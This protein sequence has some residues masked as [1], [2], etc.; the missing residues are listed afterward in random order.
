MFDGDIMSCLTVRSC[1][2]LQLDDVLFDGGIRM[3]IHGLTDLDRILI[4]RKLS[5]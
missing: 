2:V 4:Y 5:P 3:H 1:Y